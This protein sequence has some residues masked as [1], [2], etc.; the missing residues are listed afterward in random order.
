MRLTEIKKCREIMVAGSAA[1][2]MGAWWGLGVL[3]RIADRYGTRPR[4]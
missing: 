4:A 2:S 1:A 3:V